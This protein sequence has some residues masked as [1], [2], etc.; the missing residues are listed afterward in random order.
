MNLIVSG[1]KSLGETH[2]LRRSL[3]HSSI[4][5][6]SSSRVK[7]Q[8][9][10]FALKHKIKDLGIKKLLLYPK[11]DARPLAQN[12]NKKYVGNL[13]CEDLSKTKVLEFGPTLAIKIKSVRNGSQVF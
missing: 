11:T 1:F 8:K 10:G 2:Y 13:C 12:R 7:K 4:R 9:K 6:K 3:S 5:R